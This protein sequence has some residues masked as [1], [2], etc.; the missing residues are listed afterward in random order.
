MQQPR[1]DRR[2]GEPG[3]I[4]GPDD[5]E[6]QVNAGPHS[7]PHL[8]REIS[9]PRTG[10]G[11]HTERHGMARGSQ[12]VREQVPDA[13]LDAHTPDPGGKRI[14]EDVEAQD[15]VHHADNV[16]ADPADP[17]RPGV[18]GHSRRYSVEPLMSLPVVS[19]QSA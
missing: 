4:I 9:R 6:R 11:V 2:R 18:R 7:G 12:H 5:D 10:N 19:V 1:P 8:R 3:Q 16:A 15:S 17:A 13:L 14:T